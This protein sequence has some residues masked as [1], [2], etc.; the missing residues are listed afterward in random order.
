MKIVKVND[1]LSVAT[2][3]QLEEFEDIARL[4]FKSVINNRPDGEEP[5]QPDSASEEQA[6]KAHGLSYRQI[7][8]RSGAPLSLG[9]IEATQQAMSELD[10]PVLAHCRSATRSLNLWAAGEVLGGRMKGSDLIPLS[11]RTGIDLGGAYN[12][13]AHF[14]PDKV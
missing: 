1:R 13:I 10:G 6:A 8:I 2:Q 5:M 4:G 11:Q 9:D 12:W 7:P 14:H 3:P